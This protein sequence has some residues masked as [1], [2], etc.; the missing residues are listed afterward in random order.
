MQLQQVF[1]SVELCVLDGCGCGCGC[2]GAGAGSC[3]YEGEGGRRVLLRGCVS[4]ALDVMGGGKGGEGKRHTQA[5]REF[6]SERICASCMGSVAVSLCAMICGFSS[7][8]VLLFC[9]VLLLGIAPGVF[10]FSRATGGRDYRYAKLLI[11][12]LFSSVVVVMYVETFVAPAS[13]GRVA[14]ESP[15]H[16]GSGEPWRIGPGVQVPTS[17]TEPSFP[18]TLLIIALVL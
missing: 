18:S 5:R 17:T 7:F 4:E 9:F 3:G 13:P 8:E 12:W 6:K 11:I 16:F 15:P 1:C 2:C 14:N 10:F